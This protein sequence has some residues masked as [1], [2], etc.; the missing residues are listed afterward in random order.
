L[1]SA[2]TTDPA[3]SFEAAASLTLPHITKM[4]QNILAIVREHGPVSDTAI[5][6]LYM[7][8]HWPWV[9]TGQALRSRRA[10]L[11]KRGLIS[12]SGDYGETPSGRRTQKWQMA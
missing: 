10:E 4:Q 3:T 1:P 6:A 2:R 7:D 9:P 5:E 12:A 11:V 8:R